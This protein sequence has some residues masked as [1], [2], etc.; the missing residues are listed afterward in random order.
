LA[1]ETIVGIA[2]IIAILV[3]PIFALEVQKKLDKV[4]EASNRK[5]TIF[6]N[7]MMYRVTPLSPGFVQSLNLV[8]LEFDG[9]NE[10]ERCVRERWKI[11]LDHFNNYTAAADP[12]EKGR[13]LTIELLKA[14]SRY[15]KYDFDEVYL[16]RG[17]YYPKFFSDVEEEQ[18][19]LR[20]KLLEV[21]DG[22]RR[23]PIGVFEQTFPGLVDRPLELGK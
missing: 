17:A 14:M 3:S 16:R 11:L 2:S 4:H 15:F 18:H 13:Q 19:A 10:E 12:V 22:N 8:D 9:D 21:L 23:L 7:L 6:K 1:G 20:R 5:L